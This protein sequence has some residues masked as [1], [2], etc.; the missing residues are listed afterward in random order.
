MF[1][2]GIWCWT[3]E[4]DSCESTIQNSI[5]M[6]NWLM[7]LFGL[8]LS[9]WPMTCNTFC[10]LNILFWSMSDL[11]VGYETELFNQSH[12]F[13]HT[14]CY[15]GL[16][17]IWRNHIVTGLR[18]KRSLLCS[19]W[20]NISMYTSSRHPQQ[21]LYQIR[22]VAEKRNQIKPFRKIPHTLH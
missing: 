19:W 6:S 5:F 7:A 16:E 2:L 20:E 11:R 17:S 14:P 21:Y 12:Y 13:R 1:F 8:H 9:L 22:C 18:N 10:N 15:T 4:E 3:Y